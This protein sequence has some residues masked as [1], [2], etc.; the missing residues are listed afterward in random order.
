MVTG[1]AIG[2]HRSAV[3]SYD[4]RIAEKAAAHE[5]II[6]RIAVS[7]DKYVFICVFE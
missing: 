5:I 7:F 3:T 4:K 2:R 6:G 1:F